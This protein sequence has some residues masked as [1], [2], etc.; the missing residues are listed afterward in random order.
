ME[1]ANL[2]TVLRRYWR[3]LA[4]CTAAALVVGFLLT[5]AGDAVDNGKWQCK[6]AITPVAG[7][8]DTVRADQ[9]LSYAQG[10]A[11]TT[12]AAQKLGVKDVAGL[13]ARRTVAAESTQMLLFTTTGP[14]QQSCA[15]L[16]QALSEATITGYAQESK[17]SA[18]ESIKR[19]RAQADAQQ[20][21]L[22]E[23]QK[24]VSRANANDQAK[25][26]PQLSTATAALTK[27]LGAI[28]DLQNYSQTD[29]IQ[30][31][32]SIDAK[33]SGGSLLSSPSRGVRL[34]LAVVLGLS[35]GVVAALMLSRMD[36]RLR[37]RDGAE[38]AF[39]LPV[40]GEIPRLSRRL[41]RLREP[42]VT[43]RPADPATEAYR[44]LRST[45]LLTGPESLSAQFGQGG[46]DPDDRRV[47]RAVEPAPVVLVMSGRSGDGR[48][49]TV[50]NLAAAL[51]ET[52]RQVLVLDCDFRQPELNAHFGMDEGP[53]MA[54]LLSGEQLTDLVDLI[55]PTRVPNVALIAG[56]HATAYPAA[57]VLRA[58][59]VL[60]LARRYADVVLIDSSPLLNANDAY[61][62]VQH[63]DAVLVTM[64]AG[65]VRPEEADRVSELL[66]RTGVPVAG[67]AL[68]G[69]EVATGRRNR[70]LRLPGRLGGR[71][72]PGPEPEPGRAALPRPVAAEPSRPE[73]RP[74]P[75]P[76]PRRPEHRRAEHPR[77]EHQRAAD[78]RREPVYGAGEGGSRRDGTTSWGRRPAELPPEEPVETTMQLRLGE[79]R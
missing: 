64:M 10:S 78:G 3:L 77:P 5:P 55:R 79:D 53:G 31:W 34:T 30:Q 66:A 23:L 74:A 27:T 32:G 72:A 60:A 54:E 37:S 76:E 62:L 28:A 6:V 41:R 68:L 24:S 69:A 75:R 65:N 59:E 21:Q 2:F 70:S 47:R 35:L 43:A 17:K 38:E 51:G 18:D 14:T 22:D 33:E 48:T 39:N 7:A 13:T 50:A 44:S 58:G 15:E 25:L 63:A 61:D 42:L 4:A 19:L 12:A 26:Q 73:P 57:L 49:T 46:L 40:I 8:A 1:P 52:G 67:V 20:A 16:A 36:T 56:G 9:V 71:P 45:L 11:V 29:A